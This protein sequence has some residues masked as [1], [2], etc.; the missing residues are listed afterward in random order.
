MIPFIIAGSTFALAWTITT[1]SLLLQLLSHF[2]DFYNCYHY[3][4]YCFIFAVNRAILITSTLSILFIEK[5]VA[6]KVRQFVTWYFSRVW[7]RMKPKLYF[8]TTTMPVGHFG[9][10]QTKFA[11][12]VLEICS[13]CGRAFF[14]CWV[15]FLISADIN[16]A[17]PVID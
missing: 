10:N 14:R 16:H 7:I 13:I 1:T 17:L 3:H 9:T 6:A 5:S 11:D 15:I 8:L 2:Y 12:M 4:Y